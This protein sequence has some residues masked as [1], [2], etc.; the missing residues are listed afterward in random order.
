MIP[1]PHILITGGSGY[2]GRALTDYLLNHWKTASEVGDV[3]HGTN[4][5][6]VSHET[7]GQ[8]QTTTSPVSVQAPV[9]TSV[10]WVSRNANTKHP[11][12]VQV[13]TY[14]ELA[15]SEQAFDIII[16]LAGA[17]VLDKR[18]SDSCKQA[19]LDSRLKP[20]QAVLDYIERIA[21]TGH[22]PKLFISGSAIGWYG[23]QQAGDKSI[24]TEDSNFVKDDFAHQLCDKW[25]QLAKTAE[26]IAPANMPVMP[27]A[28]VRI[29]VVLSGEGG[30]DGGMIGQLKLPFSLGLGGKLGDGQQIMSWISRRDLVRAMVFIIDKNLEHN[31]EKKNEQNLS[32]TSLENLQIY[33][34]TAPKAVSNA[35]FT[36]AVGKWLNRPTVMTQPKALLKLIF[37]E[38]VT[39]LIDGQNVYP[40]NLLALGFEFIDNEVIDSF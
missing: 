38:R 26:T 35:E 40:Q 17:G 20:T 28:I 11:K 39:L 10:T 15:S 37:G 8:Q 22:T 21:Q 5:S 30:K 19:L 31:I 3:S 12:G 9:K 34:L 18:W 23:V 24:L 14:D 36:K 1:T 7:Y 32:E 27:I 16:N 13:I 6:N 29:G 2:L 33:N 4:I 25:E